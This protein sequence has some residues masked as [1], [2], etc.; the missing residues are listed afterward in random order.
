MFNKVKVSLNKVKNK[1]KLSFNKI[2]GDTMKKLI[3]YLAYLMFLLSVSCDNDNPDSSEKIVL[4]GNVPDDYTGTV[5]RVLEDNVHTIKQNSTLILNEN[6]FR[7]TH[8]YGFDRLF[9]H[10]HRYGYAHDRLVSG[11]FTKELLSNY[12]VLFINLVDDTR[13]G[14]SEEEIAAVEDFVKNGGGLFVIADHTNVYNHAEMTNPLLAPY[15]IT[16]RYEIAVDVA[17]HSVSGLGWILVSDLR[18]HPVN[19][20]IYEYS[21]ETGGP[22]DGPGGIGFTSPQGWGDAWDPNMEEG[23]YGNWTKDPGEPS[24]PQS[25]VQAVEY[26]QGRVVVVGD[27]NIFGDPYLFFIDNSGLAFNAFE[28]LAHRENDSPHLKDQ[29]S[30]G[31]NIRI[32]TKA[33]DLNMGKSGQ[34]DHYTFYTNLNRVAAVTAH[35]TRRPLPF[36][37]D[38]SMVVEPIYMPDASSLDEMNRV[39]DAGGQVALVIEPTSISEASRNFMNYWG[40]D[41][42]LKDKDGND[43]DI[44]SSG[45][46][47]SV[48]SDAVTTTEVRGKNLKLSRCAELTCPGH[49]ILS[50]ENE[51]GNCDLICSYDVSGGRFLLILTGKLFRRSDLGDVHDVPAGYREAAYMLELGLT[52]ILL[53]YKN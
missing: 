9:N 51:N 12:D 1:I 42:G 46:V 48:L 33:D 24:G 47:Y 31:L 17:P 4:G 11:R 22:L 8:M 29:P 30:E 21:L 32:D 10:L 50:A 7:Y 36:L 44:N 39:L 16:I 40:I 3:L 28:W 15:D 34:N 41:W 45:N 52:D 20:D 37:P 23:Y 25:V 18:E 6:D 53:D 5:T 13:P 49:A 14:F 43:F 38:V 35:A 2:K 19:N 26:G 27:Q